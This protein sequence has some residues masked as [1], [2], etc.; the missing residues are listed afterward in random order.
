LSDPATDIALADGGVEQA[1]APE[2]WRAGA[3][4]RILTVARLTFRE[5]RRRWVVVAAAL[6]TVAFVGLY[7]LALNQAGKDL[8]A[9]V[10]NETLSGDLLT[11]L[12]ASQLLYMGLF[13]ASFIVAVTAI[14]STVSS[15]SN[16]LDNGTLY[17]ILTRP[18]RRSELVVGKS[19]GIGAMLAVFTLA[20]TGSVVFIAWWQVDAPV[21]NVPV[22]LALFVL[23]PVILLSIAML[24]ST[25]LPTLANGIMCTAVYGLGFIGGFIEGIGS[26]IGNQTMMNI[27]I[28]SSLLI[29]LDAV[30][31]K[32]ISVLL[33]DAMFGGGMGPGAMFGAGAIPSTWM[34]V[35]AVAYPIVLI[36]IA[37][38]VFGKRDL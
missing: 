20:L 11:G 24:G 26:L 19:L 28:V 18:M 8:T 4:H 21:E 32:A 1:S 23:E 6:L 34:M 31:R 15:I 38:R 22:A 35:Y 17:A 33:P 36:W 7:A 37:T 10:V 13:V 2:G 29:P 27:G 14:F 25:R 9:G 12:I 16:E 5:A 3:L 30:H